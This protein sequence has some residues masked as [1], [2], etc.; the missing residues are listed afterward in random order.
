MERTNLKKTRIGMVVSDKQEKTITVLVERM[1]KHPIYNKYYKQSKK[2]HAHDEENT[3][4]T[5]DKV[6]VMETKKFS[7]TKTWRLVEVLE[8]KK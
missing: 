8:R 2:F 1:V 5:G 4:S 3:C 6:R 7:K